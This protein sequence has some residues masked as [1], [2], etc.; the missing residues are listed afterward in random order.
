MAQRSLATEADVGADLCGKVPPLEYIG[1]ILPHCF[2]IYIYTYVYVYMYICICI[3][4]KLIAKRNSHVQQC[5]AKNSE[6]L[7]REYGGF[8]KWGDCTPKWM[9]YKWFLKENPSI[10]GWFRGTPISG[11]LQCW[12]GEVV[13]GLDE[14]DPNNPATIADNVP[15][16][17]WCSTRMCLGRAFFAKQ[18]LM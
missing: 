5:T 14:D 1:V 15:W 10:K 2:C 7:S 18:S 13:A 16:H 3:C 9:V 6:D 11:N 8:H 4:N 17:G 12:H